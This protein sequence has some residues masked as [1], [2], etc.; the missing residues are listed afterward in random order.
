MT[1]DKFNDHLLYERDFEVIMILKS[2]IW[3]Q[4]R[5]IFLWKIILYELKFT[6]LHIQNIFSLEGNFMKIKMI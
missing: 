3:N 2:K 5:E 6:N 1:Y 4:W